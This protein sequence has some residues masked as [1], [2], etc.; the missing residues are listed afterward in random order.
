M[1]LLNVIAGSGE[2]LKLYI[3]FPDKKDTAGS[4]RSDSI[5]DD[6]YF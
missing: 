1:A 2:L 5:S 4:K 3:D 6:R